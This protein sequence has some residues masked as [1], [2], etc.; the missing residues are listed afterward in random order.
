VENK[1]P[2]GSLW[3][4]LMLLCIGC[5]LIAIGLSLGG[6]LSGVQSWVWPWHGDSR[7][8]GWGNSGGNQSIQPVDVK[9]GT[10]PANVK[11]LDIYLKAASL[12]IKQGSSAGYH[13]SDFG[14]DSLRIEVSGDTLRVEERDWQHVVN[15]GPGFARQVV[16]ITLPETMKLD[17][18]KFTIDAG[19]V[20]IE[21]LNAD[22]CSVRGGAGA[23]KIRNTIARD[24]RFQSGAGAMSFE[25]CNFVDA[26]IEAGAGRIEFKGDL[27]G[28]SK[29][30]AGAGS[31]EM[32]LAGAESEYRV[33]F[34]RGIGSVRIGDE[35]FNGVGNGS[36]GNR[37]AKREIDL[38]TGVGAARVD[39]GGSK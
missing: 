6:S 35:T 39:F 24:A 17:E 7:N 26:V 10:I 21:R 28:R 9:D 1:N 37:D 2:G 15:L 19:A 13:A 32:R 33:D 11:R 18:V 34:N 14:K 8:D 36:S 38:S 4:S 27:T 16:E 31:I 5:V 22:R 12:V 3:R 25:D 29:I 23:I 20:T 30:S